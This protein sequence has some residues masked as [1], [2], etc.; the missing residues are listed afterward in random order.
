MYGFFSNHCYIEGK[1]LF[2]KVTS[3]L[4][5]NFSHLTVTLFYVEKK[6]EKNVKKDNKYVLNVPVSR[7]SKFK[8]QGEVTMIT[9]SL[10]IVLHLQKIIKVIRLISFEGFL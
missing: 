6:Y 7:V 5:V 2:S 3:P 1:Q 9:G 10:T 8:N 4:I